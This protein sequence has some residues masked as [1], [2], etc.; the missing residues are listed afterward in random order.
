MS[1]RGSPSCDAVAQSDLV[2]DQVVMIDV[3]AG[4]TFVV[5]PARQLDQEGSPLPLESWC[6]V[7]LDR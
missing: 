5:S 3:E 4:S 7:S 1:C 6:P 2:G